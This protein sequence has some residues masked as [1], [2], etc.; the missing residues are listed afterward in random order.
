ML[1]SLK[2][3]NAVSIRWVECSKKTSSSPTKYDKRTTAP[4]N[5]S[6]CQVALQPI[7]KASLMNSSAI[8]PEEIIKFWFPEG[9]APDPKEHLEF[10]VWRMRGGANA[11]VLEKYSEITQLAAD[12]E[13][14]FWAETPEGRFALII[15]LDQFPRTVWA[16][17]AKAFSQDPKALKLCLEG[18][19]NGHFDALENVWYKTAYKIPLEHCE[20]PDHLANLDLAVAIAEALADEAPAHLKELYERAPQQ[21]KLHRA[22]VAAFGR[23]PHRNEVLG[24]QSTEAELEYLAKG[25]FPHQTDLGKQYRD[26]L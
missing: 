17:T 16:C 26:L 10:W 24:R 2:A 1:N 5:L 18:F 7:Q 4:N 6:F 15:I 20:C 14:D 21:P 3:S 11:E 23:H 13:L 22:V 12:G 9:P 25:D 8:T 19:E